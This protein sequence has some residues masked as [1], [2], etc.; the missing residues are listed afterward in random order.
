[1]YV[2]LQRI[3]FKKVTR[4]EIKGA[5][6][7]FANKVA[8]GGAFMVIIKIGRDRHRGIYPIRRNTR[9]QT[10]TGEFSRIAQG[11]CFTNVNVHIATTTWRDNRAR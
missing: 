7:R 6:R 10:H 5:A 4:A 3:Y 1:M 11:K 2:G 8:I 9:G